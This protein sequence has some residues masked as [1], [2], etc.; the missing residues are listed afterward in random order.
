[1]AANCHIRTCR[2]FDL[3]P[4]TLHP[5]AL[6]ELRDAVVH[7]V[8]RGQR[9]AV[10]GGGSLGALGRPMEADVELRLDRLSGV[11]SFEPA[12]LVLTAKA[13]TPLAE[14]EA[15]LAEHRQML[16]FEPP[17]WRGLLASEDRVPTLGGALAANLAGPRRVKTGAARD[18]FLGF[19]GVNGFGEIFKA[20][21]KVVKNVTGYDLCK[22]MAGSYGTLAILEEVTIKVVPRPEEEATLVL[23]GL[24]D[25]MAIAVLADGLNSPNE[26]SA[27]AHL[28][29]AVATRS[30]V[31]AVA[32]AG[33]ATTALRI[34]GPGS[35]IAARLGTL[36]ALF[37]GR[38]PLLELRGADSQR[39][40]R[41]VGAVRPLLAVEDR[42]VWRLSV[43]PAEGPAV[44]DAASQ[45]RDCIG[46]YDWGGGL[47]WLAAAGGGDGGASSVRAAI[48]RCGG[49]ATLVRAPAALRAE[50]PVFQPLPAALAALTRR[51]KESFDPHRLLNPGRMYAD[52]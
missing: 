14:I 18:H 44:M 24:D 38:G 6:D 12:E 5:T 46:F 4:M 31:P 27:A 48:A 43:P 45:G 17:D 3:R 25:R 41:E 28:P 21:G 42:I 30:G 29:S 16:A 15:L 32:S 33:V 51:V 9:L 26:V 22:L 52:V 2:D 20:G 49:H 1:M 7:A 8:A 19:V 39:F 35:S 13:G 36:H 34:E 11:E 10:S 23:L 50:I 40:W 47:L 37:S